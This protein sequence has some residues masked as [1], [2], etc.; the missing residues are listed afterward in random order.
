MGTLYFVL[1]NTV[2]TFVLVSFLQVKIGSK[3]LETYLMGFVRGTLAP[4]FLGQK[5]IEMNGSLNFSKDQIESI[6]SKLKE[7][8]FYKDAKTSVKE[9]IIEE[10]QGLYSKQ[11]K[12]DEDGK[13]SD[14]K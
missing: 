2:L 4:Q 13:N 3:S 10:V 8:D 5:P 1:K 6:K 12:D 9:A 7:S 11:N 14:S